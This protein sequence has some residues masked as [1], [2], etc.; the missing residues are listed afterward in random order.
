MKAVGS[1]S[2]LSSCIKELEHLRPDSECVICPRGKKK[3]K[4]L[5]SPEPS[6][7]NIENV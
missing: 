7:Q 3:K 4:F 5:E 6:E 1:I 2:Y